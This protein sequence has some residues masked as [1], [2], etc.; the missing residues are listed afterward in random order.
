MGGLEVHVGELES[1]D[2]KER[3]GKGKHTNGTL[4]QPRHGLQVIPPEVI[5]IHVDLA[6]VVDVADDAVQLERGLDEPRQP[7]HEENKA[8]D[9][10]DAGEEEALRGEDQDQDDEEDAEG[11]GDDHVGEEPGEVS[12]SI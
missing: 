1:P 4:R 2:W 11:A 6:I 10:D 5:V 8:A 3:N 12:K 7:E 9:D